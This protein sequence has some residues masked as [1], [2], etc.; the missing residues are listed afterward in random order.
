MAAQVTGGNIFLGGKEI[1]LPALP[2]A[3]P[4]NA[5]LNTLQQVYPS[6]HPFTTDITRCLCV[7]VPQEFGA[8]KP[9]RFFCGEQVLR[10]LVSSVGTD[11]QVSRQLSCRTLNTA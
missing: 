9:G 2:F 7:W 1:K 11:G 5:A 10:A 8:R 3:L 4:A 6:A